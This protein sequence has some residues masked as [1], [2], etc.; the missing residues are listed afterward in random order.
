M[1]LT[2]SKTEVSGAHEVLDT[3]I[4]EAIEN[5]KDI[6]E[7]A[8]EAADK[9]AAMEDE[10]EAQKYFRG[11]IVF[12]TKELPKGMSHFRSNQMAIITGSY[13]DQHGG[14]DTDS[15]GVMF[16]SDGSEVSWYQANQFELIS[17]DRVLGEKLIQ[18]F[19]E[20]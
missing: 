5:D 2:L 13:S 15:F 14:E 17:D 18:L 7:G 1:K 12:I 6:P 16:M 11:Q 10:F 4:E 9:L 3:F 19:K 20:V 8:M